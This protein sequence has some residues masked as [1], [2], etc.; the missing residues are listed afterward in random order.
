MI[1]VRSLI[2]LFL[3]V[4][5]A[6]LVDAQ[7]FVVNPDS[8]FVEGTT[9]DVD[10]MA[11]SYVHNLTN[12]TLE[13][14]WNKTMNDLS[15]T[16][17]SAICD[18]FGCYDSSIVSLPL[19]ILPNDSSLLIGHFYFWNVEGTGTIQLTVYD[20][21]DSVNNTFVS[22]YVA[23][24]SKAT[25]VHGVAVKKKL[26]VFPN[27]GSGIFYL[28]N[29]TQNEI[30]NLTVTDM[31]GRIVYHVE[32]TNGEKLDLQF[33]DSGVYFLSLTHGQKS[34]NEKIIIY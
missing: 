20:P 32:N 33:L 5:Y 18:A 10:I 13:L 1:R 16:W 34:L 7:K 19:Q 12:D 26:S 21:A 27:P 8:T 3:A 30:V 25:G 11:W 24:I 22:T 14:I 29:L 23:T 9:N 15:D 4:I 2:L 28:T 6:G 31:L 17:Y